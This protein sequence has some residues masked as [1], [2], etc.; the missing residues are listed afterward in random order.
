MEYSDGNVKMI[1]R[2]IEDLRNN[3]MEKVAIFAKRYFLQKGF[4]K[5]G[6]EGRDALTKEIDSVLDRYEEQ[7]F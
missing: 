6:K 7:E 2:V 4:L 1:S 5:I 3:T